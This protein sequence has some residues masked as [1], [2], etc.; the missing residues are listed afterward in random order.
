VRNDDGWD[1][2]RLMMTIPKLKLLLQTEYNGKD[3]DRF[4]IAGIKAV[5]FLLHDHLD[6]GWGASNTYDGLGKNVCEYLRVKWV[7]IPN[8]FLRRGRV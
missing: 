8:V 7:D 1:W 3:V 2:L 5:H 4:K 6:R